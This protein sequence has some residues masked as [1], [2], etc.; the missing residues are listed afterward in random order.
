MALTP[1]AK[2]EQHGDERPPKTI[3]AV[4]IDIDR[5]GKIWPKRVLRQPWERGSL[6][7][8]R[9]A[10]VVLSSV[11]KLSTWGATLNRAVNKREGVNGENGEFGWLGEANGLN[12]DG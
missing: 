8:S 10:S 9:G 2:H 3:T 4:P 7:L 6:I 5:G 11:R 12:Q 1:P